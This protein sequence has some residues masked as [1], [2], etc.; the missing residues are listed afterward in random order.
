[1][2]AWHYI[3]TGQ[4]ITDWKWYLMSCSELQWKKKLFLSSFW[5]DSRIIKFLIK[6][7]FR[8][9]YLEPGESRR[10]TLTWPREIPIRTEGPQDVV[11]IFNNYSKWLAQSTDLPKLF[12]N[13]DPGFFSPNIAEAIKDWPNLQSVTVKGLHFLQEDSPDEIGQH[14]AEFLRGVSPDSKL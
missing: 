7:I 4:P 8:L 5:K 1:M 6:R 13:A 11:G 12:I 9:P 14:V 3:R 10:P 2:R